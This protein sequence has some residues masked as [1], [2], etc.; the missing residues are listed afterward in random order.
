MSQR[1]GKPDPSSNPRSAVFLLYNLVQVTQ[2]PIS[3]RYEMS[4]LQLISF[5]TVVRIK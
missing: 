4:T 3:L 1:V 5:C 2:N